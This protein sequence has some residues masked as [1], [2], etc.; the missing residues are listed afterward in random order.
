MAKLS[1]LQKTKADHGSKEA[2]ADKVI[3]LLTA[4]EDEDQADFEH[5]IHTLSNTKLLRLLSSH[6]TLTSKYGS[7]DELVKKISQARFNGQNADYIS[8][9]STFSAPKLLDLARQHKI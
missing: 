6:E 9:I 8:K 1:P 3:K 5:R 4:H 2:L 7:S